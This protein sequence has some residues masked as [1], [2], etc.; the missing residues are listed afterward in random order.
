[1]SAGRCF[2]F[3]II[4]AAGVSARMGTPKLLLPCGGKT[5]IERV[6]AAWRASGVDRVVAVVRAGDAELASHIAQCGATVVPAE[7][8]PPDMK[9]SVLAGLN[10]L[11]EQEE[12]GPG[13]VWLTAPADLPGLDPNVMRRLCDAHDPAAP[14]VLVAGH[15]GRKGHP[16]LFPWSFAAKVAALGPE[17]GLNRLVERGGAVLV[18][19]G[20]GALCADID[21]PDDYRRWH[22]LPPGE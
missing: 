12:P 22:G 19:C 16:V 6:V 11:A 14:R 17:E 9:A 4:P 10:Y 1:M 7:P 20:T 15:Q 21:T 2:R 3:A 5:M 18:E 13:D 8:P